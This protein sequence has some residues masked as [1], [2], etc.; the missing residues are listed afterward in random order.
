MRIGSV[1]LVIWLVIGLIAAAQRNYFNDKVTCAS[2]GTIVVTVLA[3]STTSESTPSF[4]ATRSNAGLLFQSACERPVDPARPRPGRGRPGV[5]ALRAHRLHVHEPRLSSGGA[6]SRPRGAGNGRLGR[7]RIPF[8]ALMG[9][10]RANAPHV[11]WWPY[12]TSRFQRS[13][14]VAPGP[15]RC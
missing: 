3:C 11:R 12:S 4:P 6:R 7:R 2:A 15:T 1:I 10:C 5:G 14:A 13:S 8:A 9:A